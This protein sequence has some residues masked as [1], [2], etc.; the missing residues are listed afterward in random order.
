VNAKQ[1]TMRNIV[2]FCRQQVKKKKQQSWA[3]FMVV[4]PLKQHPRWKKNDD[5]DECA[6]IIVSLVEA[7]IQIKN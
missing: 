7:T 5:N 6:L 1:K 3:M 4:T 2:I